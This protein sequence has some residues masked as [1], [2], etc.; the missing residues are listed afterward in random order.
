MVHAQ[1]S[2]LICGGLSG[3]FYLRLTF[4]YNGSSLNKLSEISIKNNSLF[5]INTVS[6]VKNV[7]FK[8]NFKNNLKNQLQTFNFET[9]TNYGSANAVYNFPREG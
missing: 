9:Q 6:D 4:Y 8:N 3:D 7:D 5:K 2:T 1:D